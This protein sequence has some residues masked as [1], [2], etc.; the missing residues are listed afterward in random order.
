MKGK[1]IIGLIIAAVIFIVTGAASVFVNTMSQSMLD[2][3]KKTMLSG[4]MS[5][6]API[7]DYIAVVEV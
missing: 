2:E 3:S 7:D 4:N 6:D 5:F 1:Q